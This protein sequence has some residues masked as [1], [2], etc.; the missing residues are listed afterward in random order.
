MTTTGCSDTGLRDTVTRLLLDHLGEDLAEV[1]LDELPEPGVPE[2][3]TTLADACSTLSGGETATL[4]MLFGEVADK[5]GATGR[6]AL[7]DAR[8]PAAVLADLLT[9]EHASWRATGPAATSTPPAH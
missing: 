6:E 9:L 1:I 4:S 3:L 7:L 8:Q 2:G 5:L